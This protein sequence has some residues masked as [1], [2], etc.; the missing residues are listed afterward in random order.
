MAT[1]IIKDS[2]GVNFFKWWNANGLTITLPTAPSNS[3][4]GQLILFN[5]NQ[6]V[7]CMIKVETSLGV[8]MVSNTSIT[9]TASVSGTT[10][11]ITPSATL[12]GA[13]L[14]VFQFQ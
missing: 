6:R 10:L 7:L 13:T 12:W 9:I 11:T 14:G 5:A 1:S 4:Y 8:Y 2:V 3:H